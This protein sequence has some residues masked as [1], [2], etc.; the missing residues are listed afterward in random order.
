MGRLAD[1]YEEEPTRVQRSLPIEHLGLSDVETEHLLKSGYRTAGDLMEASEADLRSVDYITRRVWR[2]L[3]QYGPPGIDLTTI[4]G[5]GAATSTNVRDAGYETPTDLL[6]ADRSELTSI[7]GV[8]ED[9]ARK[10]QQIVD[11]AASEALYRDFGIRGNDEYPS[12]PQR[13]PEEEQRKEWPEPPEEGVALGDLDLEST[14]YFI[15]SRHLF[16]PGSEESL[17]RRKGVHRGRWAPDRD[18]TVPVASIQEANAPL[19]GEPPKKVCGHCW[20]KAK[21]LSEAVGP[22]T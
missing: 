17:C 20:N 7:G 14:D 21:K 8:T 2:D 4:P 3:S 10:I 22:G 15:R 16:R 18:E 12:E 13:A 5:I 9:R 11:P 1:H 6:E 19:S